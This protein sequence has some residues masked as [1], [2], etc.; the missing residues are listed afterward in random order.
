MKAIVKTA[1]GPGNLAYTDFPDP[2]AAAGQVIIQVQATGLCGTDLSLYHWKESMVRQFKPEPP[3]VMGH[4]FAGVVAEVG[5]GVTGLKVGD[6]VTANPMIY[7]GQCYFCKSGRHSICDDR[8]MVGL[9]FNGCFARY[10]AI[11]QENVYPL[12][13]EA[14]FEA[15]SMSEVLCV[16]LH[17]LDRVPVGPGDAVAVVGAGPMGFLI[18]LAAKAAGASRLVMTG[19]TVDADRLKVAK[20]LGAHT[21]VV[22]QENPVEAVR[23][24]TRGLGPD[25]VFECAGHPSG[26]PQALSL[27]R[28]GGRIGVL[29]QGYGESSFNTTILSYREVE[30][31]G[32]RSYDPRVWHRSYDVLASHQ[33]PLEDLITHRLPLEQAARGIELMESK[34]GLKIMF[35]PTWA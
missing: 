35:T 18:L 2:E 25:V 20:A 16:A 13:P 7:C 12:P 32:V 27:V 3:L 8:P 34:Q 19:L 26:V 23:D 17:T 11:R 6:R 21:I 30:L 28:K 10:I 9:R 15:A 24:L 4:E 33:F 29:G 1:P 31:I 14:S 22:D 5:A